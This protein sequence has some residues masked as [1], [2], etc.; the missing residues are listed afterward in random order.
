[1]IYDATRPSIILD[2]ELTLGLVEY[3]CDGHPIRL[4]PFADVVKFAEDNASRVNLYATY[5][6]RSEA[7][8]E[9]RRLLASIVPVDLFAAGL[10]PAGPEVA[11]GVDDRR[12]EVFVSLNEMRRETH[13]AEGRRAIP[14]IG[15]L[16]AVLQDPNCTL[17]Y[18]RLRASNGGLR[19]PT[20]EDLPV[21]PV[22]HEEGSPDTMV[23][24]TTVSTI[25]ALVA[26]GFEVERFPGLESSSQ[27]T[28]AN[29]SL[30]LVRDFFDGT[31]ESNDFLEFVKND[32]RGWLFPNQYVLL[33]LTD[34]KDIDCFHPP[35]GSHGHTLRLI[36][37]RAP[38]KVKSC[39]VLTTSSL[40]PDEAALITGVFTEQ[41]YEK[42]LWCWTG[43]EP[44]PG[45]ADVIPSRFYRLPSN[46]RVAKALCQRL[47]SILGSDKAGMS[48]A[49]TNP[50]C[51]NVEGRIDG[52]PK[53]APQELVVVGAHLDTVEAFTKLKPHAPAVHDAPGADDD[54]SG[55]AA[56]LTIAQTVS[57]L[58]AKY[59]RP[60]RSI[61][62][63]L[64]NK[65]EAGMDGS[66][67]CADALKKQAEAGKI[68]VVAMLQMDMIGLPTAEPANA[69]EI[70]PP[71]TNNSSCQPASAHAAGSSL[72]S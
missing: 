5:G 45:T 36:P 50:L 10:P 6:E 60:R 11:G 67:A 51:W 29:T 46:S 37:R 64:F 24:I 47:R 52:D 33:A 2:I 53:V 49:D 16:E 31:S 15:L 72:F 57:A 19:T 59:G 38:N 22:H 20:I 39:P 66:Q 28:P 55:V 70:H 3:D 62:F 23:A 48:T 71:G 18:L 12:L 65:E 32:P 54:A 69:Y 8:D 9:A 63:V 17:T 43:I 21:I 42:N 44:L 1:M 14:H 68:A 61:R 40:S 25:S 4:S 34:S 7:V 30:Y 26:R 58:A 27:G 41:A 35:R 13:I 56:V